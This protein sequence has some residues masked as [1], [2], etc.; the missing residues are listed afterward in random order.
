MNPEENQHSKYS[1]KEEWIDAVIR[2]GHHIP[3]HTLPLHLKNKIFLNSEK[4]RDGRSLFRM[5]RI[6]FR[7]EFSL[8]LS[9]VLLTSFMGLQFGFYQGNLFLSGWGRFQQ[10]KEDLGYTDLTVQQHEIKIAGA[11]LEIHN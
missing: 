1:S 8:Y 10:A 9:V 7:L 4:S 3:G 5:K 11:I 2:S 6:S